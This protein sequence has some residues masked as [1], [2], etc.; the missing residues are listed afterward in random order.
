MTK[1][2]ILLKQLKSAIYELNRPV[3][4][5]CDSNFVERKLKEIAAMYEKKGLILPTALVASNSNGALLV[6]NLL[7]TIVVFGSFD[8]N[9]HKYRI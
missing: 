2:F 4:H 8:K 6:L 5:Q 3:E 7:A 1:R 9:R